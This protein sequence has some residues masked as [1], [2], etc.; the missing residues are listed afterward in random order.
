MVKR[1]IDHQGR[2]TIPKE[3]LD[4]YNIKRNDLLDISD[5]N[6]RIIIKKYIPEYYCAVTG[7]VTSK[8][9]KIGK[10]FISDKGLQLIKKHLE[11]NKA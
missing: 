9:T 7:E 5:E 8:G 4:K 2:F 3:F 11:K 10:S 1:K 6:G